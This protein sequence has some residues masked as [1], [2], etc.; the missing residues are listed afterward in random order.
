MSSVRAVFFWLFT[1]D[2]QQKSFI[3]IRDMKSRF[4]CFERMITV[5][6]RLFASANEAS[7]EPPIKRAG[8]NRKM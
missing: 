3:T 2:D 6:P 8:P 4:M 1:S 7:Q 5:P